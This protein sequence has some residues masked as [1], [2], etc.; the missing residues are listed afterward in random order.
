MKNSVEKPNAHGIGKKKSCFVVIPK[1]N[2]YPIIHL[3]KGL[4]VM[5]LPCGGAKAGLAIL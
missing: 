3:I 1:L 4:G 2:N 5:P